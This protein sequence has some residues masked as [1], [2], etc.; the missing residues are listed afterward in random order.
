MIISM[1][2]LAKSGITLRELAETTKS[3][4]L[5]NHGSN[6]LLHVGKDY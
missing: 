6:P 2:K 1:K 4:K 3:Q 5:D